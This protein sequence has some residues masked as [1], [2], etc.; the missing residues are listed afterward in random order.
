MSLENSIHLNDVTKCFTRGGVTSHVFDNLSIDIPPGDFLAIMGPSGSG[1][2]TFLN[3]LCGF[4]RPDSGS[5]TV[6]AL[7]IDSLTET[8]LTRWRAENLGFVFQFFNL[9]P[10]LTAAQNIEIPLLLRNLS[11]RER[12][13][14]C[15]TILDL[16]SLKERAHHLPDQLSGGQQQRIGV[17]RA[18]AG[19]PKIIVC[20]EPT[21]DLDREA[22]D[23]VLTLLRLLNARFGK[24]I[25]MATHDPQA[26][27]F[28]KRTLHLEKGQFLK[29]EAA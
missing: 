12:Q 18:I 4:D 21:G 6:G 27:Q 19:D 24:T 2:S 23:D 20:D 8:R 1:K 17:G 11:R 25:I 9:L 10:T 28:A 13:A 14:R 26:A 15:E 29:K 7:R 3:L 5:I 22:A 16:L